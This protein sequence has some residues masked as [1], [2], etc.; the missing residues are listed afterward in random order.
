MLPI[1]V[2]KGD[3]APHGVILASPRNTSMFNP[4]Y[5]NPGRSAA[6]EIP[7]KLPVV[8]CYPAYKQAL[9]FGE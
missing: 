9:S 4:G 2:T 8:S 5:Q 6:L 1:N 3:H 7:Q